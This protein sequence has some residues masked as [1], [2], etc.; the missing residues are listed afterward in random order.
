[1]M[2]ENEECEEQ[3]VTNPITG[4]QD[5]IRENI[6]KYIDSARFDIL[7]IIDNEPVTPSMIADRGLVSRKTASEYITEFQ[8]CAFVNSNADNHY[9]LTYSGKFAL[10]LVEDCLETIT[11]EQLAFLSR[12]PR[13]LRFLRSLRTGPR[14]PHKLA[15][16]SADSPGRATI[17]RTF[18]T[19]EEY[20][21][22]ESCPKGYRLTTRGEEALFA[23]QK[24]LKQSEQVIAKAPFLQRLSTEFANFPTHALTDAE[25]VFSKPASPG[26]VVEAAL[27]L[28]DFRTRHFRILTSVFQPTL[29]KTYYQSTRLGLAVEPIVDSTVYE[30]IAQNEDLHYLLDNS[31]RDN[32]TLRCLEDSLTLGIGL[33]DDR[34]VAIGAYNE[35]GDGNHVAM[36]VSSN[37]ELVEWATKKYERYREQSV[38]PMDPSRVTETASIT[39]ESNS[40]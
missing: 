9:V 33:Y 36:I 10:E 24:L 8:E 38:D 4:S 14:G 18:Q 7:Q 11:R 29:F 31:K 34:K 19:F 20:G 30:R 1:M 23:Y 37:D 26:L 6:I 27:K 28:R 21:W 12:S 2:Q 3:V 32:Y 40:Q 39:Q 5:V 25:L 16:A 22:C 35:V 17:W 15:N 13:P